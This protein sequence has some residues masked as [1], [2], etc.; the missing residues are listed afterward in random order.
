LVLEAKSG[1]GVDGGLSGSVDVEDAKGRGSPAVDEL[2][3]ADLAGEDEG[4]QGVNGNGESGKEGRDGGEI[5]DALVGE[6]ESQVIAEARCGV[7]RE[8]E[9]GAVG[10]GHP[11]FFDRAVKGKGEALKDAVVWG[12][13]AEAIKGAN[14]AEG[15]AVFSENALGPAC[16]AGSID[17]IAEVIG[18]KGGKGA[19]EW[20]G[21]E[22]REVKSRVLDREDAALGEKGEG[23][24]EEGVVREQE[25]GVRFVEDEADSV[26]REGGVEG[27]ISGAGLE[28]G[29]DGEDRRDGAVK[30]QSDEGAR[31]GAFFAEEAS[32][33]V[34]TGVE[35]GIGEG[36]TVAE[37][38]DGI[39]SQG[40][41]GFKQFVQAA[42]LL[43]R[44]FFR[45]K[46]SR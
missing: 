6:K 36:E 10:E 31:A 5:R 23:P 29:Q 38:S 12:S 43:Q 19:R 1:G 16:G 35:V 20:V 8:D 14:E 41:L 44:E 2:L 30:E 11:D 15:V 33:P 40:D 18:G 27:N 9:S 24:R 42:F 26:V 21:G 45:Q 7:R 34:G 46:G 13:G 39:G 28:G 25:E 17:D 37:K 32:E 3:R 22:A 4:A